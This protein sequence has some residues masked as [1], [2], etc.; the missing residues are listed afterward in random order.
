MLP[1]IRPCEF[2]GIALSLIAVAGC[3]GG[4]ES[5]VPISGLMNVSQFT[6]PAGQ[7][8][9]VTGDLTV[10]ATG[11]ITIAGTLQVPPGVTTTFISKTA[12]LVSGTIQPA[13]GRASYKSD[14]ARAI[15][16]APGAYVASPLA[17]FSGTVK[18]PAGTGFTYTGLKVPLVSPNINITGSV[19]AG[20]GADSQAAGKPGEDG[21]SIEIGTASA[22]A[23][24]TKLAEGHL[25]PVESVAKPDKTTISGKLT[26]GDG[27]HGFDDGDGLTAGVLG[28]AGT[29]G[30]D[31]GSVNVAGDTIDLTG[32]AIAAGRGGRGGHAGQ[33]PNGTVKHAAD[34][35]SDGAAGQA[36]VS[37]SGNGGNGGSVTLTSPKITVILGTAGAG[38][39]AGSV[40]A[41]AGNGK[42]GGRGGNTFV[43][44]GV[45]GNRGQGAVASPIVA[46]AARVTLVDGGNGGASDGPT[47]KGGNGGSVE[48][49][50][51]T[52]AK[53]EV[54]GP[55][56]ISNYS[57][58]GAGSGFCATNA[59][60]GSSGGNGGVL[61]IMG[62]AHKETGDAFWGGD[63]GTGCGPGPGGK[64]GTDDAGKEVGQDGADG[65]A[66]DKCTNKTAFD[67]P[68]FEPI[69]TGDAYTVLYKFNGSVIAE[70]INVT[71]S[72]VNV[73][74]ITET[75]IPVSQMVNGKVAGKFYENADSTNGVRQYGQDILTTTTGALEQSVRYA[76]PFQIKQGLALNQPVTQTGVVQ[77]NAQPGQ[78]DSHQTYDVRTTLQAFESVTVPAGTYTGSAKVLR[79]FLRAGA[80]LSTQTEWYAPNIGQVMTTDS[81]G[82][83]SE[84]SAFT[85]GRSAKLSS[86][87][88]GRAAET[89]PL[90]GTK[91]PLR[92]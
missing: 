73:S 52:G 20:N 31:G 7:T 84:L 16:V 43:F 18:L 48:V 57:R 69:R 28:F 26:A 33:G 32:A 5:S 81:S 24:L 44:P 17:T 15:E 71:G 65:P 86:N 3:G 9:L 88:R 49:L 41:S 14:R 72:P 78:P 30:G 68:T 51:R 50:T 64:A 12:V 60:P 83:K 55:V 58:G 89:G 54:N 74:G 53:A 19:T 79:E 22:I 29:G 67:T 87:A 34:G 56:S 80:V 25:L 38:G 92:R 10:V 40:S 46:L 77:T 23:A 62:V 39:D 90:T 37:D 47:I 21:G 91:M 85:P 13:P 75:V 1:L 61:T 27:G 63:G 70:S 45:K 66:C 42:G 4:G 11:D 36:V 2:A 76:P 8:R 59:P 6:I 82:N 35:A